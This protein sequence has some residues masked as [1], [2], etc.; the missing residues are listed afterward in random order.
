[1]QFTI[2]ALYKFFRIE[3][4]HQLKDSLHLL[5]IKFSIKGT[6]IV[7]NEG[8]NGTISCPTETVHDFISNF[9]SIIPIESHEMK[10][11]TTDQDPF[12]RM[13]Y[14][15]QVLVISFLS[16]FLFRRDCR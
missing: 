3:N 16:L 6:L 14:S 1:M 12:Y 9:Q 8:I 13:V 10:F 11:S 5:C 7:A 4:C 15:K 2:V